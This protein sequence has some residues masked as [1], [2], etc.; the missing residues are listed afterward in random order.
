MSLDDLFPTGVTSAQIVLALLSVLIG[1]IVS[2]F[3]RGGVLRLARR[4]PG[5]SD[6]VAQIAA[7]F[8]QYALLLMSIGIGLAFLGA[9]VQ[10]LLAM[11]AVAVVIVILVLRGVAD[12]FAS[13]VLIQSR[14]T[15]KLG[16]QIG[17]EGPDGMIVGVV[18][19]LTGR[20]VILTTA[21]GRTVHVPNSLLLTAVLVNDSRHGARRSAL[22]VRVARTPTRDL[23]EVMGVIAG[24]AAEIEGVHTREH[25]IV[26]VESVSPTR[27][28]LTLQI[29][30]HP[31]HTSTV[32]SDAVRRVSVAL[33][34]AELDGVVAAH[35]G[36]L[37]LTAMDP[38]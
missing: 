5:V 34:A 35:P 4:T 18:R 7:R 6:S 9:N 1:W 23:D 13:G 25:P 38:L 24:A 30:H 20:S 37:P 14:Q 3:A 28:I 19:E 12:N 17:V 21:D 29:W 11:T 16:E 32:V 26:S 22:G 31:L 8:T 15:V 33:E 36:P 27:W 10:P 2:H